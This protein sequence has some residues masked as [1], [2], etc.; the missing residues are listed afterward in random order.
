MIYDLIGLIG[1]VITIA[2]AIL[3]F[4]LVYYIFSNL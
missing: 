4:A 1:G 2:L 3:P